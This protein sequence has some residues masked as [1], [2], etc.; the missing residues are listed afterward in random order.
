MN[1]LIVIGALAAVF[2]VGLIAVGISLKSFYVVPEADE[3]LVKTG[4]KAPV[5][6]VG[7]GVFVIP[8]FNKVSRVSLKAIRIPISRT[9]LDSL[10]T[11]D[12]LMAEIKGELIVQVQPAKNDDIVRAVQSLGTSDPEQMAANVKNQIDSLVT[13]ALRTAAFKKTFLELNSEKKDFAD[14]VLKLLQGDLTKLGLTLTAVTVP[15]V[16][17]GNFPEDVNDVFAAEGRRN[18]ALTVEKNRQE[19]NKI[20]REAEVLVLKQDVD[21]REASLSLELHKAQKEADQAREVAEYEAEQ[22]ALTRTKVLAQEQIIAEKEAEQTRAIRES[23]IAEQ[24][25]VDE[26][27]ITKDAT[28]AIAAA[29]AAASQAEAEEEAS[30]RREVAE[31]DRQKTQESAEID[32]QRAI[33]VATEGRKQ[34]EEEAAIARQVA[35]ANASEQEAL[36]LASQAEAEATQRAAEEKVVTVRETATADRAR[37]IVTIKAEEEAARDRIKADREAYV[38]TKGA[39]AERDAAQRRAE[40][41]RA[42]AEGK[43]AAVKAEADGAKEA[44]TAEADAYAYDR[45]TRA[46]AEFE[47]ASKEASARSELAAATLKEGEAVAESAR[48]LQEAENSIS[49]RIL[50]QAVALKTIEVAPAVVAE[51]ARPLGEVAKNMQVVQVTMPGGEGGEIQGIPGTVMHGAASA[52]GIAP[53]I[54][55]LVS[56]PEVAEVVDGL[57]S[58]V[59]EVVKEVASEVMISQLPAAEGLETGTSNGV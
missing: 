50:W 54:K 25:K 40:A 6:S 56:T 39:E 33:A 38:E 44:V 4:G 46:E 51:I 26:A 3:A 10:P 37:Q 48:L 13:D 2:V 16:K 36:A 15:H 20:N 19:T 1:T 45:K 43:A 21:A 28:V 30:K 42:T 17:Q 41:E 29:S 49:D 34:A 35:I 8:L 59:K 11:S 31:I 22:A 57:K 58:Q 55:S 7:G 23:Q 24:K 12:K 27:K 9:G 14:E 5:V 53:I 52:I 47:A 18:V 32:K